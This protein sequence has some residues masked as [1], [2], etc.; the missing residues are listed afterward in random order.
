MDS[1]YQLSKNDIYTHVDQQLLCVKVY[2]EFW[3]LRSRILDERKKEQIVVTNVTWGA[4]DVDVK[5]FVLQ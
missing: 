4:P 5:Y 2:K 1:R 3:D